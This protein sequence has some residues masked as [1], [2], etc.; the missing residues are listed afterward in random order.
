MVEPID[1]LFQELNRM[2][3]AVLVA[4]VERDGNPRQPEEVIAESTSRCRDSGRLTWVVLDW[5]L[6]HIDELD[7]EKVLDATRA[8][9]DL[10]VLGVLCDAANQRYPHPEF[11][12][13]MN[14]CSPN[15][16]L[17]PFFHR[18]ARSPLA[19]RLTEQS[20]LD[21][22]RRWNF[23]CS[24]L[25]YLDGQPTARD[26]SMPL[27]GDS[28]YSEDGVDLTLIRWM[29]SLTPAERLRTLQNTVRS[30]LKLRGLK[31]RDQAAR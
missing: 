8:C 11:A 23:L 29:L 16:T 17:V 7:V 13:L 15:P 27:A 20:A 10:A 21:V 18:V 25:C 6:G 2:G 5:L 19:H 28:A 9:G 30:L 3:A 12:R 1:R 26:E 14:A 31:M 24:E 22:F 4:N